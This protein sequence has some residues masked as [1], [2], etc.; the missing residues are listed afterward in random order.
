M[1][2]INTKCPHF[3]E[4]DSDGKNCKALFPEKMNICLLA[5][6][7]KTEKQVI[8]EL[9]T[10]IDQLRKN[11]IPGYCKDCEE[12]QGH[13]IENGRGVCSIHSYADPD[14]GFQPKLVEAH[15]FC[16]EWH[17]CYRKSIWG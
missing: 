15:S 1:K 5:V 12:S 14:E 7:E 13:K 17:K 9:R 3:D 6:F 11:Q 2:C 8:E 10:E 16:W 4:K